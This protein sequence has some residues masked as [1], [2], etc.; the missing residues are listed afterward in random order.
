MLIAVLVIIAVLLAGL[1][2]V[3]PSGGLISLAAFVCAG[4]AVTLAFSS[5]SV[6]GWVTVAGLV[7][8][9]PAAVWLGFKLLPYT[10]FVLGARIEGHAKRTGLEKFVGR[11]GVAATSLRPAGIVVIDGARLDAVS[12]SEHIDAGTEVEVLKVRSGEVVVRQVPSREL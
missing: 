4:V 10:P 3:I 9:A 5:G 1:E 12:R 8:G 2:V 7:A 6:C 11:R